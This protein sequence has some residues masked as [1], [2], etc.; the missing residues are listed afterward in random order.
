MRSALFIGFLI[1]VL[2]QDEGDEFDGLMEEIGETS[3]VLRDFALNTAPVLA[4]NHQPVAQSSVGTFGREVLFNVPAWMFGTIGDL[5]GRLKDT[6]ISIDPSLP[7]LP[8]RLLN[9]WSMGYVDHD[10]PGF[11]GE[12]VIQVVTSSSGE[13]RLQLSNGGHALTYGDIARV[14]ARNSYTLGAGPMCDVDREVDLGEMTVEECQ[15]ECSELYWFIPTAGEITTTTSTAP[16]TPA[17]CSMFRTV[18]QST[19]LQRCVICTDNI[20]PDV[21]GVDPVYRRG[22]GPGYVSPGFKIRGPVAGC[23]GPSATSYIHLPRTWTSGD[24]NSL[25]GNKWGRGR[26]HGSSGTRERT[27]LAGPPRL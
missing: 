1:W 8:H 22:V 2:A 21:S 10:N 23:E 25:F 13:E 18:R 27:F 15:I 3:E 11:T 7:G 24:L 5:T 17:Y 20:V 26:R 12:Y 6:I 16:A 14:G 19:G 9:G 4:L